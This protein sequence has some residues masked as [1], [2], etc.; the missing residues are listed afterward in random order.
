MATPFAAVAEAPVADAFHDKAAGQ[1]RSGVNVQAGPQQSVESAKS[2]KLVRSPTG[3]EY[4]ESKEYDPLA[5]HRK[6]RHALC[7]SR[8]V[9]LLSP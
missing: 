5:H 4:V 6:V 8:H 2:Y 9:P 3:H 1:A 7:Q